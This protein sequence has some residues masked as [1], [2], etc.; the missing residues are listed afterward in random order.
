MDLR[1]L[2]QT[3]KIFGILF[4]VALFFACKSQNRASTKNN[5]GW[6]PMFNGKDINDWTTKIHHYEVGDNHGDTFRVED[7]LIKVRYDQ[8]EGDFN[9][10]YGHLYSC[11]IEIRENQG[12]DFFS[13]QGRA[14][15]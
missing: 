1:E 2:L 3:S 11:Q 5:D 8:Y 12:R 6:I 13:Y 9:D 14:E 4:L 15:R 7:E 10:R